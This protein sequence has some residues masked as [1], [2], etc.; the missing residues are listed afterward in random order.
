MVKGYHAVH[1]CR[2]F[3]SGGGVS[4]YIQDFLEY[5]IREDL[6]YQNITIEFV[7]IEIDKDQIGKDKMLLLGLSIDHPIATFIR[8]TITCRKYQRKSSVNENMSRVLV[9]ITYRYWIMI[10]MVQLRSLLICCIPIHCYHVSLSQH[11]LLLKRPRWLTS[12]S[13][14]TCYMMIM[15][16]LVFHTLTYQTT[17][18]FFL[19]RWH[20]SN[21]E[22]VFIV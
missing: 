4:I 5:Y 6:C 3:R 11:V 1:K 8:L 7:L 21:D 16:L 14:T 2:P 22:S 19:Y 12:S 13:V 20:I 9:T 17:F 15:L 18:Q 10:H